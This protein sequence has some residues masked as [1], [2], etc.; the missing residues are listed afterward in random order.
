MES[1][2]EIGNRIKERRLELNYTQEQIGNAIGV[3]KSTIQRYENGLIKDLKMP[4]IQAIA[5]VL[6]VN[7]NWLI[8]KSNDKEDVCEQQKHIL[9]ANYNKLN[10]IGK[11]KLVDYSND[12]IAT[13]NYISNDYITLVAAR[14]NSEQTVKLSKKAVAESLKKPMSTGFDD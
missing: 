10:S 6:N 1:N 8:L 5:K 2:K 4:V 12:L 9:I 7:P 13:E 11:K 14:G 3:A